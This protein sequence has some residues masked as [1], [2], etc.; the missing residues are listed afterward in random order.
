[1]QFLNA[2][3]GDALEVDYNIYENLLKED[4]IKEV[5][6][7]KSEINNYV[8]EA[9]FYNTESIEIG[10]NTLSA[11]KVST[12]VIE[13]I[14]EQQQVIWK[15]KNIKYTF[16]LESNEWFTVLIS[17]LPWVLMIGIWILIMRR[18]QGG[19]GT[20]GT[21]G[22]FNF[23]KSRAKLSSQSSIKVTFKDVA[24]ADE[25]KQELEEIIEFLKEP[26]KFQKLGGKIPRGVL[27]LG[28]P[29]TG[30]TLMARAVAG[31]AGV[32]FYS[33]SGA[34]F[35]EMF[36]GVGASRVRDLFDQGKKNAPC[37]IFIDEIDAVGRHRGAG[38][39]GGHDEREQTLNALLVEMDGFEQN[40]GV[41]I[42]AATNRPDVL[43]PALLRPGRFDRQV[44]V[45]RPDVKGRE[46]ILKVHT[47]KIPLAPE[48][49]LKVLAKATPGLAGAE[50]ANMVNEAALLAARQNKKVV[51]MDDFEDAKD[52]VMMG[53][54]RKS[55][56]IS[57][58]EKKTTAY[59]E[60]GH[61][62][63]ALKIPESDPV[64]K[65]TIIPRGR[66]LGVTT[67][68]PVDE[69]HT[70]SKTYLEAT[71]AYALGGRAAEKIVF[72]SFTTGAGNDIEK[73]T[74]L[75]RKMVCEWGMSEKLGPL[76]Y[77][78]NEE[79]LFLG[80]EV[81]KHNEYSE[82]TAQEIDDEIK[83]IVFRGMER[84]EQILSE[85]ID[86]LHKLSEELLEREILDADEIS[87]IINGEELPPARRNGGNSDESEEV[88][89]HVKKLIEDKEN[90]SSDKTN[91]DTGNDSN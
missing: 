1:M 4:K 43:D 58:K 41:I 84:A 91:S 13:K 48:V 60:I 19:G 69:K 32:P 34:D 76:A 42:I 36:V 83:G 87:K 61:V 8:I 37:I 77:G 86:I 82:K 17:F 45:D 20:G 63:V 62:L 14:I 2:G 75:A 56:I 81:T 44:V 52:K 23:G 72:N 31:E 90:R 30:K 39:G 47:R 88:P 29:G 11:D 15:E 16:A 5:T 53:M 78:K 80:R 65:V 73:A 24:G 79:E 26:T 49:D 89:D 51:S 71:I 10:K 3:R 68:L 85:N 12:V 59:H 22:I 46:G 55:M 6:V 25:A 66:A 9:K 21:R 28:P 18:M 57:E 74:N 54:E 40:S 27:L 7:I 50:L 67:Y 70:Y 35:V 33:I 64:H 38:L